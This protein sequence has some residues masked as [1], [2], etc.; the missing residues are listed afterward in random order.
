[1]SGNTHELGVRMLQ[2]LAWERGIAVR[3]LPVGLTPEEIVA[4]GRQL[5]PRHFGISVSLEESIPQSFELGNRLLEVLPA[6]SSLALGGGAFRRRE[7]RSPQS[8]LRVL[9]TMDE[10]LDW[11]EPVGLKLAAPAMGLT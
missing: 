6:S 4:A 3:R 11:V 5:Q 2:L 10:Y 1:M 9:R 7:V 8:G